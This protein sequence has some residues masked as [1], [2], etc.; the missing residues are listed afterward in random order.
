[1]FSRLFPK[2]SRS[3]PI[4][5]N[6]IA[7]YDFKIAFDEEYAF[8]RL[9]ELNQ[10][11][12]LFLLDECRTTIEDDFARAVETSFKGFVTVRIESI[13]FGSIWGT[14]TLALVAGLS[15]YEFVSKYKDFYDSI[16]LLRQQL[17]AFMYSRMSRHFRGSSRNTLNVEVT[18]SS[19]PAMVAFMPA[20]QTHSEPQSSYSKA[21]FWYLLIMNVLLVAALVAL[22]YR[23]IMS[24]YFGAP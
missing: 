14:V 2:S 11:V 23:A 1:M 10:P 22:T 13:E 24:V 16:V 9:S 19:L 3:S 21:F 17:R 6:I 4:E 12:E 7:S 8:K 20:T 5:N 15:F 18:L